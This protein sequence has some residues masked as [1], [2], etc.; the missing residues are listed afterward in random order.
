ML[1]HTFF[2]TDL[3]NRPAQPSTKPSLNHSVPQSPT[4]TTPPSTT[5]PPT[6]PTRLSPHVPIDSLVD[7]SEGVETSLANEGSQDENGAPKTSPVGKFL[8][9]TYVCNASKI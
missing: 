3:Q 7:L 4:H 6:T 8:S 9:C 2:S 1:V 5:P